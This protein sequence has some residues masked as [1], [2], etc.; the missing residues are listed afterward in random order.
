MMN[1]GSCGLFLPFRVYKVSPLVVHIFWP[2]VLP[3]LKLV[4]T[5]VRKGLDEYGTRL[6]WHVIDNT[7][8]IH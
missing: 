7:G 4:C 1:R 5:V 8:D 2:D 6:Q 3:G